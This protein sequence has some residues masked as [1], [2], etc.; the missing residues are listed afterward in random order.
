MSRAVHVFPMY[1]FMAW[2]G[3]ISP[4]LFSCKF[5]TMVREDIFIPFLTFGMAMQEENNK[6]STA[7][8]MQMYRELSVYM[9]HWILK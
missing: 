2:T 1:V 8:N 7:M 3:T 6:L 4:L 9:P 5:I